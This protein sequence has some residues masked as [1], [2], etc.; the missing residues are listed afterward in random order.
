MKK[1]KKENNTL[2]GILG[3]IMTDNMLDTDFSG[4]PREGTMLSYCSLTTSSTMA[5]PHLASVSGI[6]FFLLLDV[7][8]HRPNS[9]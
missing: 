6:F 4:L 8:S 3:I 1:E 7:E 5:T 2:K 9:L